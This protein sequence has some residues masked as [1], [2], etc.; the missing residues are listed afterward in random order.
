MTDVTNP[1]EGC[2]IPKI[3]VP[4][5]FRNYNEHADNFSRLYWADNRAGGLS[6]E[7][8]AQKL[9]KFE[10]VPSKKWGLNNYSVN[11]IVFINRC[12]PDYVRTEFEEGRMIK[13]IKHIKNGEEWQNLQ[14]IFPDTPIPKY[15]EQGD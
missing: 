4:K 2:E 13:V 12:F 14:N 15:F 11:Y 3:V 6:D 7:E 9:Q 10:W 5:R 1:Y 8:L